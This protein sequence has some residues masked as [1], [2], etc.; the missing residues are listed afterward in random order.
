MKVYVLLGF[1]DWEGCAL[2]GVFGSV[3]DVLRCVESGK[4][5]WYYDKMGYVESDVGITVVGDKFEPLDV[6]SAIE[7]VEFHR[8]NSVQ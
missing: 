4:G 3:E 1:I 8:G 2:I 6:D 7:Y 5:S